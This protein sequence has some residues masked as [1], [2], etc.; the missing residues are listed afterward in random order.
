VLLYAPTWRDDRRLGGL[1]DLGALAARLGPDWTVLVRGHTETIAHDEAVDVAVSGGR[2]AAAQVV[3]VTGW[4][5]VEELFAAA[6][7]LVT[8]Y[9]SVMFDFAV[10]GRPMIFYVPDLEAYR[11]GRGWYFDLGEQAPGPLVAS[12]DDL[13]AAVGDDPGRWA[14]PYAAWRN[15]YVPYDD[16]RAS[17]RVVDLF[18]GS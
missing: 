14:A 2:D 3:D 18:W 13:V 10:T 16:G 5:V 11:A 17:A 1:L 9:S 8:D 15:R 12:L 7:L 6:D 4:P